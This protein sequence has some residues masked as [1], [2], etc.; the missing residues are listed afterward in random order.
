MDTVPTSLDDDSGNDADV[1]LINKVS[2]YSAELPPTLDIEDEQ[3][4]CIGR[5]RGA[6]HVPLNNS[7]TTRTRP[8]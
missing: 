1:G 8:G 2:V 3:M 5:N 7:S 4:P 6:P